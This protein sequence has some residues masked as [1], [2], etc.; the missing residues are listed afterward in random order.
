MESYTHLL[1]CLVFSSR[2]EKEATRLKVHFRELKKRSWFDLKSN[3]GLKIK[4]DIGSN[5]E[6][7]SGARVEKRAG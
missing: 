1:N 7:R 5:T 2:H 3:L 4:R 6:I